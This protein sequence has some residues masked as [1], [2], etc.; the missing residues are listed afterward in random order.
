MKKRIERIKRKK[1]ENSNILEGKK[2][3]KNKK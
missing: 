1:E 2:G 3:E